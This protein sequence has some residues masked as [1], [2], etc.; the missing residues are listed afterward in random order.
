MFSTFIVKRWLHQIGLFREGHLDMY[1]NACLFW[2]NLKRVDSH[3]AKIIQ[4]Q[5]SLKGCI[6]NPHI[7][8]HVMEKH[9][10]AKSHWIQAGIEPG[11]F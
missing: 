6:V 7:K 4:M 5:F 3:C 9:A 10:E 8:R 1:Q 11:T 2:R